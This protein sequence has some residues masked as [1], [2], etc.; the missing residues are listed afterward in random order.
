MFASISS[1]GYQC[2]EY[3]KKPTVIIT[4]TKQTREMKKQTNHFVNK[5]VPDL[6]TFQNKIRK[7][8]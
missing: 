3:E 4:K 1:I 8:N 7:A 2:L 5:C 6:C